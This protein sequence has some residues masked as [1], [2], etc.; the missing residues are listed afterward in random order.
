MVGRR[1]KLR[2]VE[3]KGGEC[4]VCG[5][6]DLDRPECFDF[7]HTEP[8][9]KSFQLGGCHSTMA[10]KKQQAEV[11]K[12]ILICSNCHKTLHKGSQYD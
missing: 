2:L 1:R 7:H 3:Y 6:N 9:S 8:T 12:C 10:Y 4:S 5:F 11:D